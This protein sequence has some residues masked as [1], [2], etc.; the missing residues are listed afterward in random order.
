MQTATLSLCFLAELLIRLYL[1]PP[2]IVLIDQ[3][4]TIEKDAGVGMEVGK[5]NPGKLV[6]CPHYLR[7]HRAFRKTHMCVAIGNIFTLACTV[8]HLHY[9][10]HKICV[11]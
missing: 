3:K 4:N 11:L 7:I 2:L 6:N 1:A 9:L 5:H 8:I 10:A